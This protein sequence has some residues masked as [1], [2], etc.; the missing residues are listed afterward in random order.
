MATK[1]QSKKADEAKEKPL[2]KPTQLLGAL[3]PKKEEP[4]PKPVRKPAAKTDP[5]VVELRLGSL[6]CPFAARE[7]DGMRRLAAAKA[8]E[9][10]VINKPVI[11]VE[12]STKEAGTVFGKES[13]TLRD[14][15][16]PVMPDGPSGR[17][18]YRSYLDFFGF[19]N[20]TKPGV[21]AVAPC[22]VFD[23]F[24]EAE[25]FAEGIGRGVDN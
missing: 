13:K 23:S 9:S 6:W 22:V 17:F 18:V 16:E 12:S 14:G 7:F 5:E 8:I 10:A 24:A 1:K 21:A 4:P 15:A 11:V 25:K 3:T 2:S 19:Q 20:N